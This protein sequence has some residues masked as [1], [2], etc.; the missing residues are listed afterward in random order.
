MEVFCKCARLT[1]FYIFPV[2]KEKEP[3][4]TPSPYQQVNNNKADKVIEAAGVA[5]LAAV[6]DD[7]PREDAL[8]VLQESRTET[9]I[10]T[11]S[12]GLC[13]SCIVCFLLFM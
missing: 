11:V 10:E 12:E 1:V 7:L 5:L 13:D 3:E 9:M 2:K 4:D 6:I 8:Q